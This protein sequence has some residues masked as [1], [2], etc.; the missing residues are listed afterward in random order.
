M[1]ITP[2]SGPTGFSEDG[3]SAPTIRAPIDGLTL[4]ERV[5]QISVSACLDFNTMHNSVQKILFPSPHNC[6]AKLLFSKGQA[7]KAGWLH[8]KK[9]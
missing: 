9:K 8:F 1:T 2:V 4:N 7:F 3:G 5:L 6:I